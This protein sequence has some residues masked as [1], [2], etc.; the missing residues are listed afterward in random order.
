MVNTSNQLIR[1]VWAKNLEEEF[2]NI[3]N[4]LPKYP[5]ISM[6][7]EFP[8]VVARPIGNF[9]STSD[10][11]YQLLRC[12]VDLLK[13][14]QLGIT[15]SDAE[16][17]LPS[18][19]VP[20]TWQ[21]NFKFRLDKDMYARDSIELLEKAG[22]DF[23]KNEKYGIDLEDFGEILTDSGLVLMPEIKWL[24]FHSGYDFGYLL[25]ML[26]CEPLPPNEEKFYELLHTFFPCVYDIKFIIRGLKTLKG[27]LQDVA[28]ELQ[29]QRIGTQHQAGS[30]SLLTASA[31]FKLREKYLDNKIDDSTY[32]GYLFGLRAKSPSSAPGTASNTNNNSAVASNQTKVN[33]TAA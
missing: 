28:D 2:E 4:L 29:C 7:T 9:S 20:S 10:Y 5:Y 30:D 31:F 3:R 22:I 12:N 23:S 18:D 15:L 32:K 14:I 6:D 33:L 13:I 19:G 26:T 17:N 24:S 25:K 1:E 27:G 21:F 8:G 11:H 16:G